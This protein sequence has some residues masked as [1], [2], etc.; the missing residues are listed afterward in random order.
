MAGD[1]LP[2]PCALV[3]S[4]TSIGHFTFTATSSTSSAR[5]RVI[6]PHAV[7]STHFFECDK[8]CQALKQ[9][10]VDLSRACGMCHCADC[11]L[12][13]TDDQD[14]QSC[15]IPAQLV[16]C[17][18]ARV[19]SREPTLGETV[20][21]I[22][23][24]RKF[25]CSFAV[26]TGSS[27]TSPE[28]EC[29]GADGEIVDTLAQP[30]PPP[31]I[32]SPPP[33]PAPF[34]AASSASPSSKPMGSMPPAVAPPSKS[35][36][37]TSSLKAVASAAIAPPTT[38]PPATVTA[39]P[40]AAVAAAPPAAAPPLPPLAMTAVR[41]QAAFNLGRSET[42]CMECSTGKARLTNDLAS[43][44]RLPS[45]AHV[46]IVEMREEATRGHWRA[47]FDLLPT[48]TRS[49]DQ[50]TTQL[51]SLLPLP[52]SGIYGGDVT[53]FIDRTKGLL[54]L[55]P[56]A[57]SQ[58]VVL[59]EGVDPVTQLAQQPTVAPSSTGSS[60][61]TFLGLLAVLAAAAAAAMQRP[62]LRASFT[63]RIDRALES[64]NLRQWQ[65]GSSRH[66]K[67]STTDDMAISSS[68]AFDDDYM[69]GLS[70]SMFTIGN[71][72]EGENE[73]DGVAEDEALQR[74]RRFIDAVS[75]DQTLASVAAAK[76]VQED[77]GDEAA[78]GNDD[79]LERARRLIAAVSSDSLPPSS[80]AAAKDEN[81]ADVSSADIATPDV[82][83]DKA[84]ADDNDALQRARRLIA[85]V[86][87]NGNDQAV[88]AE[89]PS[90]DSV[91]DLIESGF[92]APLLLGDGEP[93]DVLVD[94]DEPSE[95]LLGM[96]GP[97]AG[98]TDE[99]T[100][101]AAAGEEEEGDHAGLTLLRL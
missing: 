43:V 54:R 81:A 66:M 31:A 72:E 67:L 62:N 8:G 42:V 94:D 9:G 75:A 98:E 20:L 50:L 61:Y 32:F 26:P 91:V 48:P 33:S 4:S 63:S 30:M 49:A 96:L 34:A 57:D 65:M 37:P 64:V 38:A 13:A 99:A 53:Q 23:V 44:L 29:L 7:D 40:A 55:A 69:T 16:S 28:L 85:G 83:A 76:E 89:V 41:L 25:D 5:V 60:G 78:G 2:L 46:R 14:F 101:E 24:D 95:M 70:S 88:G 10:E 82:A 17:S 19:I 80:E 47:V 45:T 15:N 52:R 56:G 59:P 6:L 18:G 12:C 36:T 73:E 87:D 58:R 84:T 86:F 93:M 90:S 68:M 1:A 35:S 3:T 74:A 79:P 11:A 21:H 92:A 71:E 100:H 51:A 27:A 97:P 22:G 39:R 77:K